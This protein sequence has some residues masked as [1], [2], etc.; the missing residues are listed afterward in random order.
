MTSSVVKVCGVAL[1]VLAVAAAAAAADA[2][3]GAKSGGKD[4]PDLV[5]ALK[6]SPGCLGV[7]T[8]R[9]GSG[10]EVIFAWTDGELR[11]RGAPELRE[12]TPAGPR[13]RRPLGSRAVRVVACSCLADNRP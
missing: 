2:P 11:P 13:A 12:P 10:K 3:A 6:A 8:A 7:E 9:T 5:G 1:T 4:F